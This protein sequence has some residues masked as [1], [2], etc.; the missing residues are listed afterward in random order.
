MLRSGH[1]QLHVLFSFLTIL[2][3]VLSQLLPFLPSS[4]IAL[5]RGETQSTSRQDAL[6]GLAAAMPTSTKTAPRPTQT[7]VATKTPTSTKS[8]PRPTQ[9]PVAPKSPTPKPGPNQV[10]TPRRSSPIMFIENVGQFGAGA[11]FQ[12][13]GSGGA[14]YLAE[15]GIW[16]TALEQQ[17]E[18]IEQNPKKIADQRIQTSQKETPRKGVNLKQSFLGANPHPRLEPFNRLNTRVSYF[19][20]KDQSKWQRNVPVWGGVRYRDLYPGIDLEITSEKGQLV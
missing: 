12:V 9:T 11:R 18:N 8:A 10:T 4:G 20:G 14:M 16:L 13:R 3:L 6:A 19:I 15:D 17:K 2:S 7:L 1:R 5:A